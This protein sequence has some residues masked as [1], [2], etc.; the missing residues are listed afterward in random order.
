MTFVYL[1]ISG[2]FSYGIFEKQTKS[3]LV[4]GVVAPED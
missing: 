1:E 4:L 2:K 3:L